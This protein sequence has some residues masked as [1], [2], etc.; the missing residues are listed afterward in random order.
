MLFAL[1]IAGVA[2]ASPV[3]PVLDVWVR[4]RDEEDHRTLRTLG[5]SFVESEDGDWRRFHGAPSIA[6]LLRDTGIPYRLAASPLAKTDDGH[7][8][9]SEML[10]AMAPGQART[11]G[12]HASTTHTQA[13]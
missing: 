5:M 9:P 12:F 10:A 11:R 2:S 3:E 7:H 13:E 6:G 4:P 1:F 8:S